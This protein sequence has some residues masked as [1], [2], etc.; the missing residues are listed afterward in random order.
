MAQHP[1]S[2]RLPAFPPGHP[3]YRAVAP[4]SPADARLWSV[5]AHLGG[6]F[7]SLL[8]PLGIWVGFKDRD[9]FVRRHASQALNFHLT[10]LVAMIAFLP[11]Y[12]GAIVAA[13]VTGN[14]AVMLAAVLVALPVGL[15]LGVTVL[16]CTV[17]A[18]VAAHAGRDYRYPATIPFV[19]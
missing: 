7:L 19:R 15:A 1:R 14:P 18:A 9:P 16:V 13:G 6:T 11:L 4:V 17:M 5:F 2:N 8:A 12:F 3:A 10:L